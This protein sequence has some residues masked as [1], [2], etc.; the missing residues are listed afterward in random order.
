MSSR[1]MQY[2]HLIDSAK[3]SRVQSSSLRVYISKFKTFLKSQNI[4]LDSAVELSLFHQSHL[5]PSTHSSQEMSI[6]KFFYK[7]YMKE[8]IRMGSY[9]KR[10]ILEFCLSGMWDVS[11]QQK[12]V[13]DLENVGRFYEILT[14]GNVAPSRLAEIYFLPPDFFNDSA[15]SSAN[16]HTPPY[17]WWA[18]DFLGATNTQRRKEV[19]YIWHKG[20]T[21]SETS[22]SHADFKSAMDLVRRNQHSSGGL[23]RVRRYREE[24]PIINFK[25]TRKIEKELELFAFYKTGRDA[26]GR[27]PKDV[28]HS[29]ETQAMFM[30][31]VK[32]FFT[33]M[34]NKFINDQGLAEI[35]AS[36]KITLGLLAKSEYVI[37]FMEEIKLAAGD[38]NGSCEKIHKITQMLLNK[39]HG[40]LVL[41]ES[42]IEV[43][44]D[45]HN[46]INAMGGWQSYCRE[47]SRKLKAYYNNRIRPLQKQTR[48]PKERLQHLLDQDEPLKSMYEALE[49]SRLDLLNRWTS[50]TDF[51]REVESHV[52]V[53]MM[54]CFPLRAKHWSLMTYH[55][56]TNRNGHLRKTSNNSLEL[57]IPVREFKNG[58]KSK[59]LK[60]ISEVKFDFSNLPFLSHQTE[61]IQSFLD[62]LHPLL[63]N[64]TAVFTNCQGKEAD[65]GRIERMV[66]KWTKK[67]ISSESTYK[68]R[69]PGLPPFRPHALRAIVATHFCKQGDTNMASILLLDSEEV[70]KKYYVRDDINRKL[71]RRLRFAHPSLFG[72]AS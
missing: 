24:H 42:I 52:L 70:L 25:C 10:Q 5:N 11:E 72:I 50:T 36:S 45:Y 49:V 21:E 16:I 53:Y 48:L 61:V 19:L 31:Y 3:L 64:G 44:P 59:E 69:V 35:D 27:I 67:F 7:S 65:E 55:R 30:S 68:T 34:Y 40:W 71:S 14:E 38:Y 63:T 26:H 1:L 15:H 13:A 39:E 62:E 20:N 29:T 54:T 6:I 28:W 33:Y 66:Y 46:E 8:L 47:S 57:V 22:E 9:S 18:E 37:D 58:M 60:G 12:V 56:S 4:S 51:A 32:R 41:N 2:S 23:S 43:M 17:S